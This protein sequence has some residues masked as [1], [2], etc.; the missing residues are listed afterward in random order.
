MG[1]GIKSDI[2]YD[3][4]TDAYGR[5]NIS[6]LVDDNKAV[7]YAAATVTG[8]RAIAVPINVGG[9]VELYIGEVTGSALVPITSTAVTGT[10]YYIEL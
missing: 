10:L 6:S 3:L 4:T 2:T 5:A 7:V 8:K 9:A 1:G